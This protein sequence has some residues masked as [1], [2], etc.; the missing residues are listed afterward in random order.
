MNEEQE[1]NLTAWLQ[2]LHEEN[3]RVN[4][5]LKHQTDILEVMGVELTKCKREAEQATLRLSIICLIQVVMFV[6]SL[7]VAVGLAG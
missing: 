2:A 7:L 1:Q 3:K 5:Q 4:K 6:G